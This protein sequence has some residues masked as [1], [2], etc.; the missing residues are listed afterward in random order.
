MHI[1]ISKHDKYRLH[2]TQEQPCDED[3]YSA[4]EWES[5]Q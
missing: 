1:T 5:F 3:E 4:V 2:K